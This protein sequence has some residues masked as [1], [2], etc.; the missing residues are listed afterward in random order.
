MKPA[1]R[2]ALALWV[3]SL[4]WTAYEA[5]NGAF[6]DPLHQIAVLCTTVLGVVT[7]LVATDTD[8]LRTP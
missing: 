4:L 5:A 3:L 6:L 7:Y 8:R 2:F 1:L